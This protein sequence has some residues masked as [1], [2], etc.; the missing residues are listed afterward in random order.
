[1]TSIAAWDVPSPVALGDRFRVKVGVKCSADCTLVDTKIEIYDHE[2]A[3]V[4]TGTLG[5]V[6]WPGTSGLHWAELELDAPGSQGYYTWTV[7]FRTADLEPPHREASCNFGFATAR[8]PERVVTVEVI[9]KGANVPV[10]DAS[11]VLRPRSGYPYSDYTD[12]SGLAKVE[13]P[14]GECRVLVSEGNE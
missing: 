5:A 7:K 10:K 6:P 13:V 1:M 11:V 14:K 2:G 12:E 4:A 9:D 3:Q 8:R